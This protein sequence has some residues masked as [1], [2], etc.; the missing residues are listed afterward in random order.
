MKKKH[1]HVTSN[2]LFLLFQFFFSN[3]STESVPIERI[4]YVLYQCVF[5]TIFRNAILNTFKLARFSLS[6][7]DFRQNVKSYVQ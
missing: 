6:P 1:L 3:H 2:I 7:F 4:Y 5:T